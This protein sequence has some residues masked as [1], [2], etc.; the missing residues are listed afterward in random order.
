MQSDT[1]S[2]QIDKKKAQEIAEQEQISRFILTLKDKVAIDVQKAYLRMTDKGLFVADKYK[3]IIADLYN[4]WIEELSGNKIHRTNEKT[5]RKLFGEDLTAYLYL[6]EGKITIPG[7]LLKCNCPDVQKYRLP[8]YLGSL[9]PAKDYLNPLDPIFDGKNGISYQHDT[10]GG[11]V[12]FSVRNNVFEMPFADIKKHHSLFLTSHRV[13]RDFPL[14]EGN[15]LEAVKILKHLLTKARPVQKKEILLVPQ[16]RY[17]SSK[18]EY[19]FVGYF[20]FVIYEKITILTVYFIKDV[21]LYNFMRSEIE[22]L[23]NKSKTD[24]IGICSLRV[25]KGRFIGEMKVAGHLYDLTSHAFKEYLESIIDG[26]PEHKRYRGLF[27]IKDALTNFSNIFQLSK[28]I[29][30][31]LIRNMLPSKFTQRERYRIIEGFVFVLS[32]D[33]AIEGC[34][35]KY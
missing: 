18:I 34:I 14:L 13:K 8:T 1:T 9:T 7:A 19:L 21:A 10:G 22:F 4:N 25:Q 32:N 6:I 20:I 35:S 30:F 5:Q 16:E 12:K 11:V 23:V 33:G 17:G 24:Q 31:R 15:L 26:N 3:S 27:T 29:D 2:D 28:P